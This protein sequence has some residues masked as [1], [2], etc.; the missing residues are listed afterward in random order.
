MRDLGVDGKV[1][2]RR[3]SW[4]LGYQRIDMAGIVRIQIKFFVLGLAASWI[5]GA[6][7]I[8]GILFFSSG[9]GTMTFHE[10]IL[11][12][13]RNIKV[14]MCNLVWGVEHA[15]RLPDKDSFTL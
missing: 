10:Q 6:V 9:D 8:W 12:S 13:G 5:L 15:D 4:S 1:I 11:P 2:C 3:L 7:G 14:T